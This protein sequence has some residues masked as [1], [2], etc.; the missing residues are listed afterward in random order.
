MPT[1]TEE[2][3]YP[4]HVYQLAMTDPVK[5]GAPV[6]DEDDDTIVTDGH[7][8]A[9]TKQLANR[10]AFLNAILVQFGE[11]VYRGEAGQFS[12]YESKPVAGVFD[13]NDLRKTGLYQAGGPVANNPAGTEIGQLIVLART[14]YVGPEDPGLNSQSVTQVFFAADAIY[15]RT[16]S[17]VGIP[18]PSWTAWKVYEPSE[19]VT[20]AG[21]IQAFARNTAP[22]GWLK[23]NGQAVSR[24]AYARLFAAI[25]TT[26]GTGDGSTTFNVPDLRGEF[27][28][29]W[30]DGRSVDT[31]RTFGSA[32]ADEL[33]SHDHKIYRGTNTPVALNAAA[34]ST[35]GPNV[36]DLEITTATT[37]GSET[38][39][40][41]LS[42]LYCIRF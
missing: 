19:V 26:F 18:A 39:P 40:R 27:I 4:P 38:R 12:D 15:T 32:Q 13:F 10:T 2:L 24:T 17:G 35:M 33:K 11:P 28:R 20:P 25:G 3:L 29:G 9:A 36:G 22:T 21:A 7:S 23:A 30:A 41:N 8:N 1:I 31:G 16:T 37:G 42:L 6:F 5:G 14:A 34:D